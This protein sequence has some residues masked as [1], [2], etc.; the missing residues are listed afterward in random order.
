MK[1]PQMEPWLG[2]EEKAAVCAVIDENWITEGPRCAEFGRRLN[3]LTGARY[4]VFA[5]NGTLALFMGLLALGIGPDDEVLVPDTTFIASANAVILAGA[6]P[7]FV[8]VNPR[9]FQ[10]D[11]NRCHRKVTPRTKA[12]MPV[13]LYGMACNMAEVLGFTNLYGLAMVEDA[14]EAL[15]VRWRGI[16]TGTFGDVGCF[17]FFADKTITTGE[18]GYVVC[19]DKA[20]HEQLLYLRNQGRLERG[21]FIHPEIGYNFRITDLQAAVGLAQLDRL[22]IIAAR[23]QERLNWYRERLDGLARVHFLEV[24]P[25][26]DHIPFR[27]VLLCDNARSLM[28][29]LAS[30]N[31]EP[32]TFFYPLHRQPCFR[33]LGL[34]GDAGFP[35]AVYG[36]EHGVCLPVFPT[37]TREQV[38]YVCDCIWEF[39]RR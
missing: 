20:T 34:G 11:V 24:E 3:E 35:N 17:S 10:I 21:S 16:H 8:D 9:N 12:I 18:G 22:D 36:Y 29:Y 14:A 6:K 13:H 33:H 15:N 39:Y 30:R 25:D 2:A 38:D 31:V 1:V 37:L 28:S 26:S 23:K 5:P 4:G 7:V 19:K 27:V 32:R